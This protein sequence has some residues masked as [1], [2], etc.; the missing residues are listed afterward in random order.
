MEDE[1]GGWRMSRDAGGGQVA[2]T[3]PPHIQSTTRI[4]ALGNS[5]QEEG[6]CSEAMSY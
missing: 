5:H 4:V 6:L 2:H 3:Q 1:Q